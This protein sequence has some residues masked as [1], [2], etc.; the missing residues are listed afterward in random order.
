MERKFE[1]SASSVLSMKSALHFFAPF[2]GLVER[3]KSLPIAFVLMPNTSNEQK[4]LSVLRHSLNSRSIVLRYLHVPHI[5][6]VSNGAEVEAAIVQRV[7][8]DM[9]NFQPTYGFNNE[10]GDEPLL[11]IY[12]DLGVSHTIERDF[13]AVLTQ[14]QLNVRVQDNSGSYDRFKHFNHAEQLP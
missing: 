9:V 14:K 11:P 5:L 12:S 13:D 7:A 2:N 1:K 3:F 6:V 4:S 10:S 8:V